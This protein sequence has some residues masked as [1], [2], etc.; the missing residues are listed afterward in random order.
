MFIN[1][2]TTFNINIIHYRRLDQVLTSPHNI[3]I[4]RTIWRMASCSL[5]AIN[6][7]FSI[8]KVFFFNETGELFDCVGS[9]SLCLLN[10]AIPDTNISPL[11]VNLI[12]CYTR[13]VLRHHINLNQTI[14]DIS[15]KFLFF[16]NKEIDFIN[17][18]CIFKDKTVKSAVPN[19]LRILH[20][21]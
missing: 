12:Q 7:L 13:H 8:E 1:R 16:L 17:I 20:R 18:P 14:N 9:L 6:V 5:Q 10:V 3:N 21:L 11:F 4:L 2:G 15:L 19:Y